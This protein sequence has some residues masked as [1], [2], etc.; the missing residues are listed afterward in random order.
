MVSQA[1]QLIKQLASGGGWAWVGWQRQLV[2]Q[3]HSL[4]VLLQ[5]ASCN[6]AVNGSLHEPSVHE[7]RLRM[8]LQDTRM[9]W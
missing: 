4:G 9:S 6:G 8:L 2:L 5:I 3:K 1:V 7:Q